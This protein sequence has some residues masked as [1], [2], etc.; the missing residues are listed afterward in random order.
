[1]PSDTQTAQV[2]TTSELRKIAQE[3]AIS[4]AQKATAAAKKAEE[5][6]AAVRKAFMEREISPDAVDH[7]MTA[8]K[9]LAEQGKHE[10]L[11]LQF[12]ADLLS[13]G[14]RR[15][16]NF[17]PDWPDSLEGYGKRAFDFFQEHLKPQGYRMRAQVLD[18]PNGNLG[19]VGLFLCW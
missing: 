5:H 14:G 6:R 4:E 11:A 17:Q 7:L 1:M 8:V 2:L 18:Y 15:V 12:P 9:H 10:F 3:A 19:D 16:N 13:D